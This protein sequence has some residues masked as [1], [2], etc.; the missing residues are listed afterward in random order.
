MTNQEI[1][2]YRGTRAAVTILCGFHNWY[3]KSKILTNCSIIF[4][5]YYNYFTVLCPGLPGWAGSRRN[6]HPPTILIIIQS[7]S[8][9]SMYYDPQ[10]PPCSIYVRDNL[11][12]QP[13][14]KSCLVYFLI[15]SPPPHNPYISSCTVMS[16]IGRGP[17]DSMLLSFQD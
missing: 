2:E 4:H 12:S 7:L 6:I 3:H 10:R 5:F 11:F 9:S 13:L 15:W 1:G 16:L 17:N 14:S 8:D